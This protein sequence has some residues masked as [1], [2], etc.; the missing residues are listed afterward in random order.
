MDLISKS[1][2]FTKLTHLM[3]EYNEV[4]DVGINSIASAE[5]MSSLVRLYIDGN[6]HTDE[7]FNSLGDSEYLTKLE[8]PEF[9]REETEMDVFEEEEEFEDIEI[10]D[11]E[12][13]ESLEEEE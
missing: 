8:Y 3:I 12:E 4:T 11:V 10:E 2:Y 6:H 9:D 1:I 5:N 13:E 7:G